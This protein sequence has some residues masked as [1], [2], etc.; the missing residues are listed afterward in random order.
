MSVLPLSFLGYS[1]S[2]F[3]VMVTV[4]RCFTAAVVSSCVFRRHD[5]LLIRGAM[6]KKLIHLLMGSFKCHVKIMDSLVSLHFNE[7]CQNYLLSNDE[8]F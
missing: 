7:T 5:V 6:K 3:Q 8:M 2:S 4:N 1:S